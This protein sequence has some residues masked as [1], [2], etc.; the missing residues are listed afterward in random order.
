MESHGSEK[1]KAKRS[2]VEK[3]TR[4]VRQ[5]VRMWE[6]TVN[7]RLFWQYFGNNCLT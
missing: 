2:K 3:I 7:N 5:P 4:L 1:K 6:N